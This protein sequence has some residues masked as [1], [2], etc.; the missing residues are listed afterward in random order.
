MNFL[1]YLLEFESEEV[2]RANKSSRSSGAVGSNS[3]GF[4]YVLNNI[5]K[6]KTILDFGSG[7]DA[8][9]TFAL[10]NAGFKFVTAY[11]FGNNVKEYHDTDALSKQYD[12]VMV[13]NVLNVQSTEAMLNGTLDQIVS[14]MRP[15]NICICN[16]PLSP[17]YYSNFSTK[18]VED[19][20]KL[21]FKSVERVGGTPSAPVWKCTR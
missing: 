10:R 5:D 3:L 9:Q 17:R 18:D 20:L 15:N 19:R 14:V 12:V 13:N 4:R 21:F 16:Y 7:R 6:N 8:V 11:E 2:K 1:T